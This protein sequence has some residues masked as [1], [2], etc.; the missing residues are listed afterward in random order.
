MCMGGVPKPPPPQPPPEP[1]RLAEVKGGQKTTQRS[2]K[3]KRAPRSLK[4][5]AVVK[6]PGVGLN[7]IETKD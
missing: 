4:S 3:S 6:G 5:A 1:D 2:A 7:T